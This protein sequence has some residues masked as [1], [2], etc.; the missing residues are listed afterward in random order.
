MKAIKKFRVTIIVVLVCFFFSGCNSVNQSQIVGTWAVK[1]KSRKY[2]NDSQKKAKAVIVFESTGN[3]SAYEI[4][5]DLVFDQPSA[6]DGLVTGSGTWLILHDM[7]RIQLNF[8]DFKVDRRS[9]VSYGCHLYISRSWSGIG[10][11]YPQ[12]GVD[13]IRII[14]ERK[15]PGQN[16]DSH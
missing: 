8:K 3:F 7:D 10:L 4:P 13:G 2:F 16:L 11:F 15:E 12:G 14:L 5:A 9:E 1:E 6:G